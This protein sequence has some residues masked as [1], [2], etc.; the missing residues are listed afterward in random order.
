MKSLKVALAALAAGAL[1]GILFAPAKGSITRRRISQHA[2]TYAD[3]IKNS[4]EELSETVTQTLD[5]V[6]GEVATFR[7]TLLH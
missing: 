1:A 6:K 4:F 7:K 2:T 3:E 5:S